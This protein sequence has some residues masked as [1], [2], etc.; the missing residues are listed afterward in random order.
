MIMAMRR[1]RTEEGTVDTA[2]P[3]DTNFTI[4]VRG[5]VIPYTMEVRPNRV[6]AAIQ[7]MAGGEVKVLVPHGFSAEQGLEM[8]RDK[9]DW[10]LKHYMQ[11]RAMPGKDFVSGTRFDFLG[12]PVILVIDQTPGYVVTE[13]ELMDESDLTV[14]C[15]Q[16]QLVDPATIRDLLAEWYRAETKRIVPDRLDEWASYMGCQPT[17][18]RINEY[19]TRWGYCRSDGLIAINWQI[20]QAPLEALDYVLVHELA[21]LQF[22]DHKNGFWKAVGQAYPGYEVQKQWLRRHAASL[23]W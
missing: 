23:Q 15:A 9:A 19:K 22:P 17:G 13:V 5:V 7:V 21:H 3:T 14:R 16:G 18:L 2:M 1:E 4:T 10:V 11:R 6:N 8:L 12:Q 20:I